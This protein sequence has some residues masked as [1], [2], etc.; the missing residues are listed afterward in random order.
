MTLV[1][2]LVR[3]ERKRTPVCRGCAKSIYDATAFE[4]DGRL[5]CKDCI[6]GTEWFRFGVRYLADGICSNCDEEFE[7]GLDVL[8]KQ[9]CPDCIDHF[10]VFI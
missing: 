1:D 7:D 3:A 10:R 2:A 8:G 6:D 9:Y 4:V 5:F